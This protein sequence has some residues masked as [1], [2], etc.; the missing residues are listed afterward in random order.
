MNYIFGATLHFVLSQELAN[1]Q[2]LQEDLKAD[3]GQQ[4]EAGSSPDAARIRSPRY[5]EGATD[6]SGIGQ[7][8]PPE[9]A[10]V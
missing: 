4:A 9:P 6:R 3:V 7:G 5:F 2:D 8:E 10:G 1:E